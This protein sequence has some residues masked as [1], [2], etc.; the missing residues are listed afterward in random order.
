LKNDHFKRMIT[1]TGDNIKRL[2]CTS[3]P[4]V[5]TMKP[6]SILYHCHK[7]LDPPTTVTSFID[8]PIVMKMDMFNVYVQV[9]LSQQWI[10]K[11][12][13]GFLK[14]ASYIRNSPNI[15]FMQI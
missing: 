3:Y 5:K 10:S 13:F 12:H 14:R 6:T 4:N 15:L 8:D 11:F 1:L 9:V 2:H 7:I